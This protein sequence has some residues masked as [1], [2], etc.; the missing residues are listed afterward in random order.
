MS[1]PSNG[2][3]DVGTVIFISTVILFN[4][5]FMDHKMYSSFFF[6]FFSGF[7]QRYR[8]RRKSSCQFHVAR[9]ALEL[10]RNV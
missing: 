2:N 5:H 9:R 3:S 1:L 4:L 6:F 8:G 7:T 10:I